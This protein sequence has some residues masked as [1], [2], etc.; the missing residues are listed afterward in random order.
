M[1]CAHPS[2]RHVFY[3]GTIGIEA[4]MSEFSKAGNDGK[5][6]VGEKIREKVFRNKN[7]TK[8]DRY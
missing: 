7:D 8:T 1:R 3:Q 4:D 2:F 5:I 6:V